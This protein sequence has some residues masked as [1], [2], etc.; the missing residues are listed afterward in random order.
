M[1]R[2]L[3]TG[4]AGFI[5]SH[6]VDAIVERDLGEVVVVDSLRRGRLSYLSHHDGNPAVRFVE[7]DIRD[8]E[9][10]EAS[11]RGVDTIFHLAAQSNVMGAS[12]D[13][14]Y[15]V[16]TNVMGTVNVLR[17]ACEAGVSRLVFSSSREVYGEPE[18]LPVGEACPLAPKNLYGASKVAGEMYCRAFQSR[19]L[20]V[21]ILRFANVYGPRDTERVIP[22]WLQRARCGLDL[23]VYGGNQ[24]IDFVWVQDAVD[25]L[26][27]ASETISLPGPINVGSGQGTPIIRLAERILQLTGSTSNVLLQPARSEEVVGFVADVTAMKRH[28]QVD[29]A[30]DPLGHLSALVGS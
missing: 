23:E 24:V 22:L 13:A 3:V 15:S 25:A 20:D 16:E 6:L 14:A 21:R 5:G 9:A 28:L 30:A 12:L 19:G 4:G 1:T 2:Y 11:C 26:I 17:G 18:S 8:A 7:A 27:C 29:S 10:T